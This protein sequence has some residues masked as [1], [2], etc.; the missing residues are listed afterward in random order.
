GGKPNTYNYEPIEAGG[1]LRGREIDLDS[2]ANSNSTIEV[3]YPKQVVIQRQV[4]A[5]V[6]DLIARRQGRIRS[7]CQMVGDGISHRSL[8]LDAAVREHRDK[9]IGKS[10]CPRGFGPRTLLHGRRRWKLQQRATDADLGSAV[11]LG[12]ILPTWFRS[13]FGADLISARN[14]YGSL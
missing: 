1:G 4:F 14:A 10:E 3:A 7:R 2:H 9:A 6:L 13:K 5:V 11:R 8:D 12:R